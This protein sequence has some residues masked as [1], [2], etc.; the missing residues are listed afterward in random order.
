MLNYVV[1]EGK[2]VIM[3]TNGVSHESTAPS[4]WPKDVGIHAIEIYFPPY[5]VEQ[6]ELEKFDGVSEGKYTL[7]TSVE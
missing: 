4:G 6:K 1:T 3:P 5:F 7:G 2:F